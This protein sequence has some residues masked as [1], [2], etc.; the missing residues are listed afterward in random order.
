M[1][2]AI[3]TT[4]TLL[5]TLWPAAEKSWLKMILLALAGSVLLTISAKIQ[6]PFYP[7]PMTMQTF[8]VLVIGMAFGWKL[9]AATVLLYL[10]EGALWLPV[11]AGTPAKGIGLAYMSGPTGGYLIGFLISAGFLGYLGEKGFDRGIASTLVAMIAGTAIIFVFGFA[12]LAHLIGAE[13][14]YTFGVSPFFWAAAFK[15]LLAALVL[16]GCWRYLGRRSE[17]TISE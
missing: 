10:V 7:V 5:S 15:I 2:T 11:F 3:G 1:N 12:W 14:A 17:R 8:A 16:P 9:G 13:K 4:P 6:I